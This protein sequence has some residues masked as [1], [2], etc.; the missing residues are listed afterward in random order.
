MPIRQAKDRAAFEAEDAFNK[1]RQWTT[2][3]ANSAA[4]EARLGDRPFDGA[5]A[6]QRGWIDN[7]RQVNR[8]S[9]SLLAADERLHALTMKEIDKAEY[10]TGH[11]LDISLDTQ[12]NVY[13]ATSDVASGRRSQYAPRVE[14]IVGGLRAE[15]SQLR[16][17]GMSSRI[18]RAHDVARMQIDADRADF[19]GAFEVKQHASLDE[20]D[21]S[22]REVN[23][24][25]RDVS[26]AKTSIPDSSNKQVITD[27]YDDSFNRRGVMTGYVRPSLT[28]PIRKRCGSSATRTRRWISRKRRNLTPCNMAPAWRLLRR[29]LHLHGLRTSNK[30]AS[31]MVNDAKFKLV[32]TR[33]RTTVELSAMPSTASGG[34]RTFV[35]TCIEYGTEVVPESAGHIDYVPRCIQIDAAQ[36]LPQAMETLA[37]EFVHAMTL[38]TPLFVLAGETLLERNTE[39]MARLA[40]AWREQ[41]DAHDV[42]RHLGEALKRSRAWKWGSKLFTG[43]TRPASGVA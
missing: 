28:S 23:R 9:P 31:V 36:T 25:S 14:S 11:A 6:V 13:R 42:Q 10:E 19:F 41:C 24:I 22:G 38:G 3:D 21:V 1:V 7:Q 20:V 29:G 32:L 2:T 18:P 33:D 43:A 12:A 27:Q 26:D 34:Y 15:E 37:H 4:A 35:T 39:M 8:N 17:G 40:E 16:Q 5:R 30:W